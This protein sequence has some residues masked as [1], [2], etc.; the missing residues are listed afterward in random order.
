MSNYEEMAAEADKYFPFYNGFEPERQQ[1]KDGDVILALTMANGVKVIEYHE[2][3]FDLN[4]IRRWWP[5]R[6]IKKNEKFFL[7]TPSMGERL[8]D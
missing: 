4:Q 1:P 5:T 8:K 3:S 6:L 7:G 2:D